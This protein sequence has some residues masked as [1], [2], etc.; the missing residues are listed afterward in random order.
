MRQVKY[1]LLFLLCCTQYVVAE[2][3]WHYNGFVSQSFISTSDNNFFGHT[4]DAISTDFR[5]LALILT[6]SPFHSVDFSAQLL[7]RKAGAADDGSPRVD[8]AFLSWRF[9]ETAD[10][11]Q[12]FTL[13]KVKVP[14]GFLNETRESPFGRRSIWVPQ[15]VYPDRSRNSRMTANQLL[16]FGEYRADDWM[17]GLKTGYGKS[18]PD[19]DEMVDYLQGVTEVKHIHFDSTTRWNMQLNADYAGGRVR[20]AFSRESIPISFKGTVQVFDV[21][22]LNL[23]E[24]EKGYTNQL[25]LEWNEQDFSL[26]SEL[27]KTKVVSK[28]LAASVAGLANIAYA[29]GWYLEPRF[30]VS[31]RWDVYAR[32]DI[33]VF[34]INDRAGEKYHSVTGMPAFSKFVYERLLGTSYRPAQNWLIMAEV[35]AINGTLWSIVRDMPADEAPKRHWNMAAISVAWRF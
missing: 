15:G 14:F 12:G 5:E 13:G 25:S 1:L 31:P 27:H 29:E 19:V 33:C 18:A 34:D 6:G 2:D 3:K 16:Y 11:T 32:Y 8:Y 35:H 9:Q 30:H 4:N 10:V 23:D 28:G 26:T 7:S 21:I 24:T 22:T 17:L 20:V